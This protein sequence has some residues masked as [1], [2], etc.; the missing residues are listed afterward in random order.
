M[1]GSGQVG[2][3]PEGRIVP[4]LR[5]PLESRIFESLGLTPAGA[6]VTVTVGRGVFLD[7]FDGWRS[8]EDS[9]AS[10]SL[11]AEATGCAKE[12]GSGNTDKLNG[13]G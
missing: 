4:S 7:G 10:A 8:K 2:G 6:L 3:G 9:E 12:G 5:T 11:G 13:R 1:S